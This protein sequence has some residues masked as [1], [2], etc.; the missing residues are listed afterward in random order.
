LI[1]A[2][3]ALSSCGGGGGG[4]SASP[5]PSPD[6][7]LTMQPANVTV[8]QGS[9]A[10]VTV[11]ITGVNGFN[12]QVSIVFTGMP[13][14]VTASPAQFTLTSG[15]QQTVAIAA[16]ATAAAASA[17]LTVTAT[18]GS[19]THGGKV[20]LVVSAAPDFTL[21][22]QPPSVT[23]PPGSSTSVAIGL[24]GLNG[25]DSQAAITITGMPAGVTATPSTFNL[26]AGEQ[27]T[28]TITVATTTAAYGA[29]LTVTAI[30]GS[31]N[32]SGQLALDFGI[33]QPSVFPPLRT[34]YVRT[35]AQWDWG[36]LPDTPVPWILYEPVTRRFFVSNTWLNRIDVFDAASEL[37][38]A[39]ISIP[40]P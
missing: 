5:T 25:F 3:L 33:P 38:I 13:G 24:T 1:L 30:S 40:E 10:S 32:H 9:S 35:D 37:K 8:V 27:Q 6:F 31:L 19:L 28:V 21:T 12:S 23:L 20:A 36:F 39:E 4:S 16:A 26:S 14:G 2:A 34:R 15:G 22:M 29:Y 11:G 17:T 7:T 18:A